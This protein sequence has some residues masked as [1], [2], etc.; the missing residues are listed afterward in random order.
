ML[1]LRPDAVVHHDAARHVLHV[2]TD[3][4]H[5]VGDLVDEGDLG[6][7]EGVGGVFDQLGCAPL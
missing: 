3:L 7:E 5:E 4:L 1:K 6:G 2:G